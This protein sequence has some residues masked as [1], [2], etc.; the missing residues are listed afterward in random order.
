MNIKHFALLFALSCVLGCIKLTGPEN[1]DKQFPLELKMEGT[2]FGGDFTWDE[3]RVFDFE[4][5]VLCRSNQ[6]FTAGTGPVGIRLLETTDVSL[7]DTTLIFPIFDTSSFVF[8]KLFA[9]VGERWLESNTVE[10]KSNGQPANGTPISSVFFP[11]SNWVITLKSE[12]SGVTSARLVLHDLNRGKVF[13]SNIIYSNNL[14]TRTGMS[15]GY[16]NNGPELYIVT[17]TTYRRLSLPTLA[18]LSQKTAVSPPFASVETSRNTLLFSHPILEKAIALR[19]KANFSAISEFPDANYFSKH[20]TL[21]VLDTT[22]TGAN[23]LEASEAHVRLFH[24]DNLTGQITDDKTVPQISGNGYFSNNLPITTNRQAFLANGAGIIR[25]RNL[26]PIGD[27]SVA[28]NGMVAS[29]AVFSDEDPDLLYVS[30]VT[31]ADNRMVLRKIKVSNPSPYIEI[32]LPFSIGVASVGK[33]KGGIVG[34][35]VQFSKFNVEY[36]KG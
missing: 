20:R 7:T 19:Q 11:D 36:I 32:Q 4:R 33:V 30:G 5:Y 15:I 34:I 22:P 35:F 9:R 2:S 25:N 1:D 23:I 14:S 10:I 27:V 18:Q 6:P 28:L 17:N 8:Y 16:G 26:D 21:A 3:V 12:V 13:N 31:I 24:I 29:S